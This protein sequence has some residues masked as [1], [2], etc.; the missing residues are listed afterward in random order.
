MRKEKNRPPINGTV[1]KYSANF[2]DENHIKSIRII[3]GRMI[4]G[5]PNDILVHRCLSVVV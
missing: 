4:V 3:N 1:I 2:S 5:I